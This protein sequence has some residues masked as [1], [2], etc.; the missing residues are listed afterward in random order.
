MHPRGQGLRTGIQGKNRIFSIPHSNELEINED[1]KPMTPAAGSFIPRSAGGTHNAQPSWE[2]LAVYE[3]ANGKT[4]DEPGSGF[5]P[6]NPFAGRDPR[7][8]Q[9][10]VAPGEKVCN[11]E[12]NP[13]PDKLETY[14]YEAG[15]MVTNKD[16]K[17]TAH[18]TDV[19]SQKACVTPGEAA[20]SRTT[21]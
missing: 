2:L 20:A 12:W 17:Q 1:G 7:C 11:I 14:D 5:D 4:I 15:K 9:T 6:H 3:M 19:A 18:I 16:S 8:C 13:A 21:L 10:F